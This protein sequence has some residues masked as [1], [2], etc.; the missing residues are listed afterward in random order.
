MGEVG[1]SELRRAGKASVGFQDDLM[2]GALVHAPEEEGEVGKL[3][4]ANKR[5]R[6]SDKDVRRRMKARAASG[7][8]LQKGVFVA[9]KLSWSH[10]FL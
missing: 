2:R 10:F 3:G 6:L 7:D 9:E 4:S 1:A 8:S 5:S